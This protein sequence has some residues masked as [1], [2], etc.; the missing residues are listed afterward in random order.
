M[1]TVVTL[2]AV[3]VL[4]VV[5]SAFRKAIKAMSERK[6]RDPKHPLRVRAEKLLW[7][8]ELLMIALGI[9]VVWKLLTIPMS[10]CM[11]IAYPK[12]RLAIVIV[13]GLSFAI[14]LIW[15]PYVHFEAD[16]ICAGGDD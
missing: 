1:L 12:A 6:P 7:L 16:S 8:Y 10:A 3:L 9:E 11:E 13:A 5:W 14:G 15:A 4:V 2:I